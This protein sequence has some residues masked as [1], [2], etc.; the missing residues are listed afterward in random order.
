MVMEQKAYM[1][2]YVR[3]RKKFVSKKAMAMVQKENLIQTMR[4]ISSAVPSINHVAAEKNTKEAIQSG[5]FVK[6]VENSKSSEIVVQPNL[7]SSLKEELSNNIGKISSEPSIL[8]NND[9]SSIQK[10]NLVKATDLA[11][12]A[13]NK[14]AHSSVVTTVLSGGSY[15]NNEPMGD[16]SF[17]EEKT[18]S[19][20]CSSSVANGLGDLASDMAKDD[21]LIS[22]VLPDSIIQETIASKKPKNEKVR[23][24]R[25]KEQ[26]VD[27]SISQ[28][29]LL[30]QGPL[31]KISKSRVI[32]MHL[33]TKMM[34]R[35]ALSLRKRKKSKKM[36]QQSKL[37]LL[38]KEGFP[39]NTGSVVAVASSGVEISYSM[40]CSTDSG[41][42]VN[43]SCSR[44]GD[45][46]ASK[47][48]K[49]NSNCNSSAGKLD[50][51]L[52]SRIKSNQA[53]LASVKP[54]KVTISM[55]AQCNDGDVSFAEKQNLP[56]QNG[57]L[58][59]TTGWDGI[60]FSSK[61]AEDNGSEVVTIGHV[62]DEWDEEYDRGK[63]KKVRGPRNDFSGPN[64]FQEIASKKAKLKP[65]TGQRMSSVNEP[66]RI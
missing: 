36:K 20:D 3:D 33:S 32:G 6:H 65:K 30:P 38:D 31:K 17:L 39:A 53:V 10:P 55:E 14:C 29:D 57:V 15:S 13:E 51:V 48:F 42:V 63:R 18:S 9:N 37:A 40:T 22:V 35:A 11:R 66:F 60:A 28:G 5:L 47:E 52:D 12:C 64:V 1:L 34:C 62:P 24:V 25:L 49:K 61:I 19:R 59:E 58:V 41:M 7:T 4:N 21:K 8:E 44:E 16:S 26:R 56:P 50:E 54:P 43:G 45:K 46:D 2:F 23:K 27:K